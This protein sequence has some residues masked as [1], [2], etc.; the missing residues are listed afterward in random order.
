MQY[1]LS[2]G[3]ERFR[4]AN[5]EDY[6]TRL[7]PPLKTR[8]L[9]HRR[10]RRY[11]SMRAETSIHSP[12]LLMSPSSQDIVRS[13]RLLYRNVLYAVQYATPAKYTARTLLQNAYRT[14]IAADYDAQKINNTV[15]FL[16]G[17]AREKGLE[18]KILKS[19]LHTWYWDIH[20]RKTA[21]RCFL[22]RHNAL[23]LC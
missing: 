10:G 8:G 11:Y 18:H 13:Y 6:L 21:K 4:L 19:L 17:A 14:G 22:S 12:R 23:I 9:A 15:T 5:S 7:I 16:E 1:M 3:K 20:D 2:F